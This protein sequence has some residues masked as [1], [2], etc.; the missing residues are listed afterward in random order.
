MTPS[1]PFE[2]RT[3]PMPVPRRTP[4]DRSGGRPGTGPEAEPGTEPDTE[5]GA[6]RDIRPAPDAW[7]AAAIPAHLTGELPIDAIVPIPMSLQ[8]D[9]LTAPPLE[10]TG[11]PSTARTEALPVAPHGRRSAARLSGDPVP[12]RR[13]WLSTLLSGALVTAAG[14]AV[15]RW[16]SG[17]AAD[18]LG[19]ALYAVLVLVVVRFAVP[20][21]SRAV[22]GG[23]ALA[24]CALVELAQLS[25]VPAAVVAAVPQSRYLLGTTFVA[26]DLLA[27]AVGVLMGVLL[28]IVV[29]HR[30]T[31]GQPVSLAG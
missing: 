30:P 31:S 18:A 8:L 26:T 27:Y 28:L 12:A 24:I 5:P 23:V 1:T 7:S 29:R 3:G 2:P 20:G 22:Q 4:A 25:G 9:F 10:Q 14:L 6:E 19:D 13:P 11:A 21:R 15:A 17:A 16:G